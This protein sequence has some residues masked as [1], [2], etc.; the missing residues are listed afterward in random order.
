MKKNRTIASRIILGFSI[1]S[2]L[3]LIVGLTG[4]V[5]LG[6]IHDKS[7]S[8]VNSTMPGALVLDL[9]K[10]TLSREYANLEK[11]VRTKDL[12]LRPDIIKKC[13]DF[14]T[15]TNK[16][17]AEYEK[18]ILTERDRSFFTRLTEE[19]R[20]HNQN[21]DRM[22]EL[23]STEPDDAK[24]YE[25]MDKVYLP[26]Y[27][28][29]RDLLLDHIAYLRGTSI[30]TGS[31]AEDA[32]LRARSVIATGSALVILL[33]VTIAFIIIR[34]TNGVL[35]TVIT[36]IDEGS[37][38]VASAAAEVSSASNTLAAGAS[39]QAASIEETSSSLEEMSS[40]TAHNADNARK[41]KSVA[42]EMR[43][44]ADSSATSMKEMQKAMD[45]IKESSAGI[46]QI[47]KTIEDIAFQT[48]ILALNA[49]VEAARAGEAGAGFAVVAEEV[50]NLAQRSAQSAKETSGKIEGAVNNSERGV[51]I[52]AKVADSL[53]TIVEKTHAMNSLVSE[54]AN[55]S[56]EQDKGISQ[57]TT[58]VQQMD[59][60]T[61]SNAANAEE[62]A[63]ASEEL[64]AHASV[65]KETVVDL[66]SL[67]RSDAAA[68]AG[69]TAASTHVSTYA[70]PHPAAKSAKGGTHLL[71]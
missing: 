25:A 27:R 49:A 56:E 19:R 31:A 1:I 35:S 32:M 2:A 44:A 11:L 8:L 14:V 33:S 42:D 34:K 65:L 36:A 46:S 21:R 17:L 28:V 24:I 13:D 4:F 61:Q 22:I 54:I 41:A 18:T 38:Q 45:A 40:M 68:Q 62:T 16:W 71:R 70:A 60:V 12:S 43:D 39:Q 58:A 7:A 29:V 3:A 55:A 66:M 30:E 15:D 51:A 20:R 50:R 48:N 10:D 52:S 9:V 23:I 5:S 53:G 64:N 26:Q 69:H 57:L 67:V 47:I 63:S 37:S 59:K 6:M